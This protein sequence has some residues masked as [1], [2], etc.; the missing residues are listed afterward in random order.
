MNK[1]YEEN[2]I[3][4][5]A[6]AIRSKNGSPEKYTVSQMA[7]AI[8]NIP[9]GGGGITPNGTLEITTNGMHDVAN[10]AYANV[11]VENESGGSGLP[12]N[13]ITGTF[14]VPEDTQESQLVTHN[15]GVIPSGVFV[16]VDELSN[17]NALK[18]KTIGGMRLGRI[19]AIVF[20][21]AGA[22]SYGAIENIVDITEN[23][24]TIKPRS[25]TNYPFSAELTYRWCVWI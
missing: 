16:I 24:F 18:S 23:T 15:A 7:S 8:S 4:N 12:S 9:Q 25:E 20:S 2:D 1:L 19:E 10:Y 3:Q 17:P 21:N 14:T 13:I 6:D 22:M 11:I 5:I